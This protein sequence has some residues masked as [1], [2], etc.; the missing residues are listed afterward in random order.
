MD[1]YYALFKKTLQDADVTFRDLSNKASQCLMDIN[2][3][4]HEI[5]I[6]KQV[7]DHRSS[8]WETMHNIPAR[9]QETQEHLRRWVAGKPEE[10]PRCPWRGDSCNPYAVRDASYSGIDRIEKDAQGVQNKVRSLV[11]IPPHKVL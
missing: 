10:C 11:H 3:V 8:V 5:D 2:D 1:V 4:L 9:G 6:I 7:L